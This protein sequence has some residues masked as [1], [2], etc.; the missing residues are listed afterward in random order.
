MAGLVATGQILFDRASA[1]LDSV[2]FPTLDKLADA[3]KSCPGMSIEVAG[4]ASADGDAESNKLLSLKRAQSVVS[5]LVRAGVEQSK[6][7]SAGYG[8][9]RPIA[10]NDTSENMARN[11]RIE[12]TVRPN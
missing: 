9:E 1:E 2:S 7:T 4:H 3:A 5:Y 6:L 12:F 8:A 10:P 11:R